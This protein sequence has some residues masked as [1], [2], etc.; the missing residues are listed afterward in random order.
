MPSTKA[1]RNYEGLAAKA[2]RLASNLAASEQELD[3]VNA[4]LTGML[5]DAETAVNTL[6][7]PNVPCH[8]QCAAWPRGSRD[9][10]QARI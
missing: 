8:W 6:R 4:R 5:A 7:C 3:C 1:R 2:A 9:V 10:L